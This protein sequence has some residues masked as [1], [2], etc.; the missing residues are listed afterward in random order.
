[1]RDVRRRERLAGLKRVSRRER[2]AGKAVIRSNFENSPSERALPTR[3]ANPSSE[4]K[5]LMG[6]GSPCDLV[7]NKEKRQQPVGLFDEARM[8]LRGL[9]RMVD[10]RGGIT[11]NSIHQSSML[12]AILTTDVKAA[13]G[14]MT[15]PVF[16]LA[17]GLQTVSASIQEPLVC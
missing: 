11:D 1:M 12:A 3:L 6:R 17:R 10:L 16:P 15:Q 9:K 13:S 2:L 7:K 5:L 8:H 14:L 4:P